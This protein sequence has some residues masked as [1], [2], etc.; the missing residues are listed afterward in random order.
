M[1]LKH[2]RTCK[3]E[4]QSISFHVS[5]KTLSLR[6]AISTILMGDHVHGWVCHFGLKC[7]SWTTMNCGTSGRSPCTA[8]GNL[9]Y[10]SVREGNLLASRHFGSKRQWARYSVDFYFV[11]DHLII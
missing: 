8:L 2:A 7:S 3:L 11:M 5:G 9:L 4:L 1:S 6:V 10:K